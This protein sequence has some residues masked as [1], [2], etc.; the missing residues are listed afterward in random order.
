MNPTTTLATPRRAAPPT[1]GDI[2]RQGAPQS[3]TGRP[4][5]RRRL[6]RQHWQYAAT[7]VIWLTSLFVVA[8]WVKGGGIEDAVSLGSDLFMSIGRLA[9]LISANLLLLQVILLAQIPLFER[10]FG[11]AGITRMHRLTGIWSFSLMVAH[12][13]LITM[14]YSLQGRMGLL[15]QF[16]DFTLHYPDM[17]FADIAVLLIILVMI[18]SARRARRRLRYESWHLLH[19]WAY[20]GVALAIPHMLS[21]GGDFLTSPLA[22]AYWWTLWGVAAASIVIFRAGMPLMRSLRHGVRVS[23][24]IPDGSRGVTVQMTGRDLDRLGAHAG[25]FFT[26]RFLDGHGWTRGHPFS[27]SAAPTATTL[28]IS[29]RVVGDG[30]RRLARLK[31]GTRVLLEGP[32]GHMTGQERGEGG[33]LMLAAGAGVAP[34]V[35]ILEEE[36][37]APGQA[38]LITRDHDESELMRSEAIRRLV[39][40]KG[41]VHRP[42]DG[43]RARRGAGWLPAGHAGWSGAQ[44][45]QRLAPRSGRIGIDRCEVYVCGPDPWMDAVLRD[46]TRAG[47]SADR[48]HSESFN[49]VPEPSPAPE[50]QNH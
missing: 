47:F 27:L 46:L 32:F 34:M 12:I 44:L 8:I 1:S 45:L 29:A 15:S 36:T 49:P 25:Q 30:T 16:W 6:S 19:L 33:L 39:Q 50:R 5:A 22:T 37:F 31:P 2:R 18:T 24:V 4:P 43:P 7:A 35:S 11:R 28:Q 10:G 21:T 3:S 42:M 20:L 48:I 23:R 9:G 17:I 13:M 40:E 26:W 41:L 38:V 14:A